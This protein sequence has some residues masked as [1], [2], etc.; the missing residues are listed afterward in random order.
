MGEREGRM[1][2]TLDAGTAQM[3]RLHVDRLESELGFRP[4]AH[5]VV[6]GLIA[7]AVVAA[8]RGKR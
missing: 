6:S 3:L 5:Q 7:Q 2:V 1:N 4:T 8:G